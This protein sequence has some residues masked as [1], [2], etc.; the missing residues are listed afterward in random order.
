MNVAELELFHS[1]T[2]SS[3][4][5]PFPS[6]L[7][8]P[9][10]P[11]HNLTSNVD[12]STV[13]CVFHLSRNSC[14][15]I[16]FSELFI[17]NTRF[18]SIPTASGVLVNLTAKMHFWE[19]V[20]IDLES[21]ERE[22]FKNTQTFYY[23]PRNNWE[24]QVLPRSELQTPG[25]PV[26]PASRAELRCQTNN[27][28][29][30][31]L[32]CSQRILA[33]RHYYKRWEYMPAFFFRFEVAFFY[34]CLVGVSAVGRLGGGAPVEHQQQQHHDCPPSQL[35]QRGKLHSE[36][37]MGGYTNRQFY[38]VCILKSWDFEE[39]YLVSWLF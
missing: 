8:L 17:T 35:Q 21:W 19:K 2:L 25:R 3:P 39:W 13:V 7:S 1:L 5:L 31:Q 6:R 20:R 32:I 27:L 10:A 12:I 4:S 28:F 14:F 11:P 9:P 18:F 23:W 24:N 30:K 22:N 38:N 26:W 36:Q 15:N 34:H 33:T 37:Q 16:V 29:A